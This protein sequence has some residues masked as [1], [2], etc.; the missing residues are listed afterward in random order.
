ML[1]A[2]RMWNMRSVPAQEKERFAKARSSGQIAYTCRR[3]RLFMQAH[4]DL[5]ND[6]L[7]VLLTLCP[8]RL[9]GTRPMRRRPLFGLLQWPGRDITVHTLLGDL[10]DL[11]SIRMY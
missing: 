9:S 10:A 2:V 11:L 6:Y 8:R 7:F 3:F 5:P 1:G 4:C